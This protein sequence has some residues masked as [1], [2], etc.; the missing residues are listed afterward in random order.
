MAQLIAFP[1]RAGHFRPLPCLHNTCGV[2]MAIQCLR[3]HEQALTC[4]L[5]TR[6]MSAVCQSC[7]ALWDVTVI[8]T[9][10]C[11]E[12]VASLLRVTDVSRRRQTSPGRQGCSWLRKMHPLP[13]GWSRLLLCGTFLI[14][15]GA[16]SKL[17]KCMRLRATGGPGDEGGANLLQQVF[18]SRFTGPGAG[19]GI[20]ARCPKQAALPVAKWSLA[21][22]CPRAGL[23]RE[24]REPHL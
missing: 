18:Q 5:L 4:V 1:V 10:T 20:N 22:S 3:G 17:A 24:S 11:G 16:G 14:R 7:P 13:P 23:G 8:L 9:S 6:G 15:C 12:R 2:D 19:C 21:P